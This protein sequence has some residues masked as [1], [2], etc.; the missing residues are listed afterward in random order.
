MKR[1]VIAIVALLIFGGARLPLEIHL[2]REQ[3][4]AG[5]HGTELGLPLRQQIGQMGFVAALSGFR[6]LVAAV[7]W[8]E[9]HSAW[10]N[11]EWGRMAGLFQTVTTLQPKSTLYWDVSGWHMAWNASVSALENKKKQPSAA[12]REREARNYYELGRKFYED[13]LRSNPDSGEL[14]QKLAILERDKFQD[15]AAAAEAFLTAARKPDARP[16]YRRMAAYEMAKVPGRER[17][18]YDLMKELY[19]EGESQH[20]P[21]LIKG[22]K[23][24][25][26]K[27]GVP[28]DQRIK[29]GA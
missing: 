27:L 25:E 3:V 9:A 14:W 2:S 7:L 12:L 17:E 8:I 6:S 26:E 16:Y 5:F 29:G 4:T 19:R 21:T 13:G 24:L 1:A 28:P 11:V 10:E 23:A 18:A 22:L 15:H 20:L